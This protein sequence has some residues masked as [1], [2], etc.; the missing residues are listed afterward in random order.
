MDISTPRGMS[1]FHILRR[2]GATTKIFTGMFSIR[3]VATPMCGP[4][5]KSIMAMITFHKE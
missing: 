4:M 5:A 3:I 1:G 2:L